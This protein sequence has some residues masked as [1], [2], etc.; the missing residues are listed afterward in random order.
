MSDISRAPLSPGPGG[1]G[2]RHRGKIDPAVIHN[3]DRDQ[4]EHGE[5]NRQLDHRAA[6][7]GAGQAA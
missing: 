5:D 7:V 4:D 1:I 3:S 2:H 6:A